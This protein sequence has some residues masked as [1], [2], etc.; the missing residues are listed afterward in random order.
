VRDYWGYSPHWRAGEQ[1]AYGA[2]APEHNRLGRVVYP[3]PHQPSVRRLFY[4][5]Y[6]DRYIDYMHSRAFGRASQS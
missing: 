6:L 2:L 3:F 5:T 4:R 1:G